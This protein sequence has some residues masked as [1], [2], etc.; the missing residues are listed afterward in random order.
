MASSTPNSLF[1]STN[2]IV[3][4]PS[5]P[6]SNNAILEEVTQSPSESFINSPLEEVLQNPVLTLL[7][8]IWILQVVLIIFEILLLFTIISKI[9]YSY[10]FKF[11]WLDKIFTANKAQNIR[12]LI[13]KT[14]KFITFIR[15]YNIFMFV[16]FIIVISIFNL[17]FFS[18]FFFQWENMI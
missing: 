5:T 7:Y 4:S 8:C 17:F 1:T 16:L 10:N 3:S 11:N 2:S 14:F 18:F 12:A 9:F 15:D 13:L 6:P